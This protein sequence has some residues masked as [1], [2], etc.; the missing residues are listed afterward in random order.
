MFGIFFH[1][2]LATTTTIKNILGHLEIPAEYS[3]I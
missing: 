2:N 1:H 3:G